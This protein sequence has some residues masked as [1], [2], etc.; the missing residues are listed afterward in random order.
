MDSFDFLS[1]LDARYQSALLPL[2][3]YCGQNCLIKNRVKVLFIDDKRGFN[4][5]AKYILQEIGLKS[6]VDK[7]EG[8]IRYFKDL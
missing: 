3:R 2:S 4:Y 1:P 6:V 7:I 5:F 8:I